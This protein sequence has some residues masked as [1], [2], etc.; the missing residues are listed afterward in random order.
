MPTSVNSPALDGTA[1]TTGGNNGATPSRPVYDNVTPGVVIRDGVGGAIITSSNTTSLKFTNAGLDLATPDPNNTAGGKVTVTGSNA[2]LH[3][4]SFTIELF[5]QKDRHANFTN[6]VS[7]SRVDGNGTSWM[8]DIDGNANVRVR[9][10]S[11]ALGTTGTGYNQNFTTSTKINSG[12]WYHI[13]MTY[14]EVLD[15][16]VLKGQM[17]LFVDYQQVRQGFTANLLVYDNNPLSIGSAGGGRAFDGWIDHI[18]YSDAVLTTDQFLR[19][20]TVVIPEPAAIA[21]LGIAGAASLR[22]R[23]GC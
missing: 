14:Q 17:T 20:E 12:Q 6:L 4:R 2:L 16:D 23:R 1:G 11:Q 13:A 8:I 10:D 18:R 21:L 19:A 15:A 3:D 5:A 22:R 7:K 9:I